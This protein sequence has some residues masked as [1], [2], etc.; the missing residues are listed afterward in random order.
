MEQYIQPFIKV[1]ESVFQEFCRTE[2]NAG[3]VYFVSKDEYVTKWDI[4]GIIGLSGEATGAVAI[5]MKDTTAFKVTKTLTGKE[6]KHIDSDVTDAVGEIINIIAGNVKKEFEEELRIKISLPTI[7]KGVAHTIV[8]PTEKTRIIC[9]P[10]SIFSDQELCL[11]IA[12]A[13][14]NK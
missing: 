13:P 11:S 9:I 1:C 4:S 6:H 2:V 7:V 3:R 14:A 5:S 10:F 12:V 8:W